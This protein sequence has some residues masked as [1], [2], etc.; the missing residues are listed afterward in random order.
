MNKDNI[1]SI[2]TQVFSSIC[3]K[4]IAPGETKILF[5]PLIEP[6]DVLN[7]V[8]IRGTSLPFPVTS[9]AINGTLKETIE[10]G[11]APKYTEEEKR[12]TTVSQQATD[13]AQRVVDEKIATDVYNHV[14]VY[15]SV[16]DPA[17]TYDTNT[18]VIVI[19]D[20]AVS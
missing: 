11:N 18:I 10:C 15:E 12:Q 4:I 5:N 17:T 9:I 16:F 19:E 6:G 3:E 14:V 1:S 20:T 8:A 2:E 13:I 7:G